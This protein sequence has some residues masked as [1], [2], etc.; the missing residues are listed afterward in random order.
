LKTSFILSV[1]S[2]GNAQCI[3]NE[4]IDLA[5]IGSLVIKRASTIEFNDGSQLW[6]VR[7]ADM[8]PTDPP[9]FTSPFRSECLYWEVETLNGRLP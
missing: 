8:K 1:A 5:E 6:E 9:A 4:V 2:D 7:W 3:Y